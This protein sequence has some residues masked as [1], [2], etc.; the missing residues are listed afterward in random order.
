M[1]L[2][3]RI[4]ALERSLPNQG[5]AIT[6]LFADGTSVVWREGNRRLS[7][8]FAGISARAD[9]TDRQQRDL[10][11]VRRSVKSQEPDDAQ[12]VQ[13]LSA[14]LNTPASPP[15]EMEPLPEDWTANLD[16]DVEL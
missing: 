7:P 13:L 9:L 1:N 5:G 10:E 6:L 4:Q 11:D 3:R 8:L 12:M 16:T 14:I 2:K 15:D